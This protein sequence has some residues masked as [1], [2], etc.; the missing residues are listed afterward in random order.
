MPRMNQPYEER[1]KFACK[2]LSC[3]TVMK[4]VHEKCPRCNSEMVRISYRARP[5]KRGSSQ[6]LKKKWKTFWYLFA[7]WIPESAR[8]TWKLSPNGKEMGHDP[9]Q[10]IKQTKTK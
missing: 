7:H 6:G 1:H 10:F 5:P 2:N 9:Y 8:S 4:G 3:Q